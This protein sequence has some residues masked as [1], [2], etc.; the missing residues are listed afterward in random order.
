VFLAILEGP[1]AKV[2]CYGLATLRPDALRFS[3]YVLVSQTRIPLRRD[4][5]RVAEDLL[6]RSQTLAVLHPPASEGMAQLVNMKP[7]DPR[8]ASAVLRQPLL[9]SEAYQSPHPVLQLT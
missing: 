7:G 1:V 3:H 2:D 4:D 9:A 8:L 5:G 6:Q